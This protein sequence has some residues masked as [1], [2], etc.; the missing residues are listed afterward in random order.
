MSVSIQPDDYPDGPLPPSLNCL[1]PKQRAFVL[2]YTLGE[3]GIRGV[4]YKSYMAAGFE[5]KDQFSASAGA[6]ALMRER[7]IREAIADIR[8]ELEKEALGKMKSWAS[9]ALKAQDLLDKALDTALNPKVAEATNSAVYLDSERITVI[10]EV[11]DRALGKPTQKVEKEIGERL[12]DIIKRVA[13]GKPRLSLMQ[14]AD[15]EVFSPD[16]ELP[17]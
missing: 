2:T 6:S 10:K 3:D 1:T 15:A 17:Q 13:A 5:S 14:T 4:L 9:M 16:Q 11:L 7:K 8:N 12:A